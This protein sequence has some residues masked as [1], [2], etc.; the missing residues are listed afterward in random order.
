MA[1]EYK[2]SSG[3]KGN[4]AIIGAGASGCMCAYFLLKAGADVTLFDFGEPLRTLLPTGGGRC[5]LAHAEFDFRELAKNY[6]RGEKF[7]YSVFSR[8][9]TADT[10]ELFE[11]IGV[12]TYI[13]ENGR[14]FPES[15][16]AKDVRKKILENLN[17]AQFA[18]EKINSIE[19]IE[20]GY[21]LVGTS[22]YFFSHVVIAIGGHSSFNILKNFDIK[23][24]APKPS[25]VGLNT[26]IKMPSGIVLKNVLSKDL[27]IK[28]DILFTHFGI[29]GP[30]TYTISSIKA[31]EEFPYKLTFDLY[32]QEFDL[33]KLLNTY[34]HKDLKNILA[35][36]FPLNFAKNILGEL[37]GIKAHKINGAV[38]DSILDKIHN[39]EVTV[40]GTNRGE[41]TVTAGGVNLDEV[42]PKT[43]E[44]KNFPNLYF[45]GECLD[46]DGFC[47]GFNLQNAWSTAFSAS[48]SILSD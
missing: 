43:M 42:N 16:S 9:S 40:T 45:I 21:K 5:N 4:I 27:N 3:C 36:I 22:A 6:P 8:F 25:L 31:R 39:F 23:I 24:T 12:K 15:N 10:I 19:R 47:G 48:Q 35:E 18:R 1:Q 7:L 32:P 17:K 41:E 37:S 44:A 33:Q 14:I 20:G 38:R 11:N 29:S 2:N 13:Q 26:D 34:P 46:I 28:D 30:L